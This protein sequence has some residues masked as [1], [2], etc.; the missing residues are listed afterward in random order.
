MPPKWSVKHSVN[1]T[2]FQCVCIICLYK[3]VYLCLF[4][5][6]YIY[7]H[8]FTIVNVCEIRVACCLCFTFSV[9]IRS[10]SRR[11]GHSSI[12][13]VLVNNGERL[14][15]GANAFQKLALFKFICNQQF[16]LNISSCLLSSFKAFWRVS[17]ISEMWSFNC[18]VLKQFLG[19]Q[20]VEKRYCGLGRKN[21]KPKWRQQT[22]MACGK[23][24]NKRILCDNSSL[25][26]SPL[27]I[28]LTT[29]IYCC[30]HCVV[31]I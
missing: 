27:F 11:L 8:L 21:Q 23:N 20:I 19:R 29:Q 4:I 3:I 31:G 7:N 24:P 13:W 16:Y 26:R 22:I 6:M 28:L 2:L 17:I 12:V 5:W 15:F 10:G 14:K 1:T 9:G 25:F 18:D 30:Q